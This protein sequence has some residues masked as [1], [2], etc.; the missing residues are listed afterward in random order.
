MIRRSLAGRL[1]AWTLPAIAVAVVLPLLLIRW[2][3]PW[4]AGLISTALGIALAAWLIRRALLP[5][6]ALFR[7]LA[8]SV[9]TYRDG[10]YNFGVHWTGS[11]D[12][13]GEL[14]RRHAELGEVLREQRQALVQRELLLDTMVQ[15]TPVS[16]LL[17]SAGGD[18]E[19]RVVFSNLTARKLLNSGWKMEGRRLAELLEQAPSALREAL[20]R[21]GD[22][23]FSI[24]EKE[25][26]AGRRRLGSWR[27]GRHRGRGVPPG[28]QALPAQRSPP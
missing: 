4:L 16:M 6:N 21:G 14:V 13:L 7:A 17:L 8:G 20:G 19:P 5:V 24:G 27:P 25:A 28:A 12:E 9:N 3:G 22:S 11:D 10:E 26:S 2:L 18:G 1:L 15:N 23:L